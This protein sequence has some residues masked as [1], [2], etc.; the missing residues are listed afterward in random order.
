[1]V[2]VCKNCNKEFIGH[3]CNY[4]GQSADTHKINYNYL[5]HEIQHGLFHLDKG[6]IYTTKELF[7]RPGHTIKEYIAGKRVK[8]FKPVAYVLVLATIYALL[9]H[10]LKIE[11]VFDEMSVGLEKVEE[12]KSNEF[13]KTLKGSFDW[14][15]E[16]YAYTTLFL[17]PVI[18]FSSYL[19]FRKSKYN[20]IEHLILNTYIAGQRIIVFILVLPL[21]ALAKSEQMLSNIGN[22]ETILWVSLMTWT[23]I[24]FFDN[25]T[26]FRNL[27][28]TIKCFIY[29]GIQLLLLIIIVTIILGVAYGKNGLTIKI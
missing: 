7:T 2:H 21:L 9:A 3:Y 22:L 13:L 10:V 15:K 27:L 20:Y 4:C 14:L 16:H 1:M 8:H 24:Q 5:W 29:L 28:K 11:T 6:I 17:L 26:I 18:S 12:A 25:N 23:Y 19:A